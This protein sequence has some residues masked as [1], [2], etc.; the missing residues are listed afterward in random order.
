MSGTALPAGGRSPFRRKGPNRPSVDNASRVLAS[1]NRVPIQFTPVQG[2]HGPVQGLTHVIGDV[3]TIASPKLGELGNCVYHT[4][5][6][7]PWTFR[8]RA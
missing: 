8:G 4:D 5:T 7:A 1:T 3:V 2:R 6:I